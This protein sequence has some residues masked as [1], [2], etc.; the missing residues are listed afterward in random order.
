[1]PWTRLG[2]LSFSWIKVGREGG[3]EGENRN[4]TRAKLLPFLLQGTNPKMAPATR[5]SVLVFR[6]G[7]G[8][9]QLID[10][11]ESREGSRGAV[12]PVDMGGLLCC[13]D[14]NG[15]GWRQRETMLYELA[16]VTGITDS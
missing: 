12:R 11:V 3:W 10:V 15:G 1:M 4:R 8:G 5:S 9:G 13:G 6:Y 14:Q 16:I 2:H 7:G